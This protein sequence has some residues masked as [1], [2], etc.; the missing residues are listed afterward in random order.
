MAISNCQTLGGLLQE[1][2]DKTELNEATEEWSD[3]YTKIARGESTDYD[4]Y[5]KALDRYYAAQKDYEQRKSAYEKTASYA[6]RNPVEAGKRFLDKLDSAIYRKKLDIEFGIED[7][8]GITQK[9]WTESARKEYDFTKRLNDLSS[10]D[11][12]APE[13]AARKADL[14]NSLKAYY[15]TPIGKLD[16]YK[17]AMSKA[18]DFVNSPEVDAWDAYNEAYDKTRKGK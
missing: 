5:Y 1:E 16:M 9:E 14:D 13:L 12:Y 15:K 4:T 18:K 17:D 2:P 7:A 6:I 3:L 10:D 11:Y 8:L